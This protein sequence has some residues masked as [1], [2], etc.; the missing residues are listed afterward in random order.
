V[1]YLLDTCVV[2]YFLQ[3]G[4]ER[5]LAAAARRCPMAVVEQV[6]RELE[7]DPG[8]GGQPFTRWLSASGIEVRPLLTTSPAFSVF[9][10]L[11]SANEKKER[12]S[13][14]RASIALAAFDDTLSFVTNDQGAV[15]IALR[16][17]WTPG[18]RLL[19]LFVFL[20]RLFDIEALR[21][22]SVVDDVLRHANTKIRPTCWP[23][24][25]AGL[26]AGGAET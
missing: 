12:H 20:R 10:Q 13:G 23:S 21:D 22:P 11:R 18:E 16:E 6:A 8:R 15:W 1:T 2:S 7:G 26:V 19:G 24:W 17:L 9:A 5:E 4:R 3:G 14:E 25:W